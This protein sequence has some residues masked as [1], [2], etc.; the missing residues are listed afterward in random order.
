VDEGRCQQLSET[1]LAARALAGSS[2]AWDEIV[3]RHSHRVLLMLLARKVPWDAAHDLVQEVWLRLVRQQ[4][5]GRLKSL[6]LPGLAIAQAEW[7]AREEDRTRRRRERIAEAR[8]AGL[9]DDPVDTGQEADLEERAERRER[10][11]LV[12]RQL[13]SCP[14]RARQIF[15]AVYGAGGRSHAEVARQ[16][17]ISVQRVRQAVCEVRSRIRVAL[18]EKESGGET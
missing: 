3:R 11:D 17:G 14:P 13:A 6:T 18:K 7:L 5:E 9:S 10:M 2:P 8:V 1:E 15:Q 12:R 16:L 4:R